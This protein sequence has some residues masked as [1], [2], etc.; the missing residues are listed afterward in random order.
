MGARERLLS[1]AGVERLA[2][3]RIKAK[4]HVNTRGLYA[5]KI[6][7]TPWNMS[8]VYSGLFFLIILLIFHFHLLISINTDE[9]MQFESSK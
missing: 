6:K 3:R 9:V 7:H 1:R 2:T 4:Q 5:G 8:Y